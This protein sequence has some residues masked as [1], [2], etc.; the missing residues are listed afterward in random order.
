MEILEIKCVVP[1]LIDVP[2]QELCRT[3]LELDR[4]DCRTAHHYRIDAT[5]KAWDIEL[6]EDV[7]G[8]V[9]ER[10]LKEHNFLLPRTSL[11]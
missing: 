2:T 9:T 8:K 6:E 5:P 3:N 11:E 7:P 10:S 4:E 1:R